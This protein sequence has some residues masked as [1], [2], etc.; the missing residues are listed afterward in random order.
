MFFRVK[1]VMSENLVSVP[2][3]ILVASVAEVNSARAVRVGAHGGMR[4]A[5]GG[6]R[7]AFGGMRFAFGGMRFAFGGM[8]FAFGGMRFAFPPYRTAVLSIDS[9]AD[10]ELDN[11]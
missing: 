7:F 1:D 10:C 9:T 11:C 3:T 8:R 2:A 4:F 5:F 6:M